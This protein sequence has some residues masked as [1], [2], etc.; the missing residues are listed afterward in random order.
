MVI[1]SSQFLHESKSW[2]MK[3]DTAWNRALST[4]HTLCPRYTWNV[5]ATVSLLSLAPLSQ[6][7]LMFINTALGKIAQTEELGDN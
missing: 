7:L 5:L 3:R 1:Q 4:D 2:R 6:G